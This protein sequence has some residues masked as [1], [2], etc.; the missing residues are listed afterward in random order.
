MYHGRLIAA[1]LPSFARKMSGRGKT[2]ARRVCTGFK[3]KIS[4]EARENG[5]GHDA[6]HIEV[7]AVGRPTVIG[8]ADKFMRRS[9]LGRIPPN[10]FASQHRN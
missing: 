9:S 1:A 8:R 5:V 7:D 3:F 10:L 2:G 4:G 6:V